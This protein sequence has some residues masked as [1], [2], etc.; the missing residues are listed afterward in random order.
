MS[1][2]DALLIDFL[3]DSGLISR[4]ELDMCTQ[5]A[6]EIGRDVGSVLVQKGKLSP[7]ELR[8]IEGRLLG[9]PFVKLSEKRIPFDTLA[10]I[11]EPIS[12]AHN[13]V[14]IDADDETVSVAVLDLDTLYHVE[15]LF[16]GK[17]KII[18]RFTDEDSITHAIKQYHTYLKH[19]F[20]DT[21]Q[22][23]SAL[24]KHLADAQFD[25]H[26]AADHISVSYIVDALL[27]H[28]LLAEATH[29]HIEPVGEELVITYR[30]A[31][32]L[33]EALVLPQHT[34]EPIVAR[35]KALAELDLTETRLSQ[36]GAFRARIDE[37][38]VA[39]RVT[40]QPALCG[41][42]VLVGI[43]RGGTSGFTLEDLVFMENAVNMCI[44]P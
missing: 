25:R 41:E 23:E 31:G 1:S 40:V 43:V 38:Q 39:F 8:T 11:P 37:R 2:R 15:P 18:T 35:L 28:A 24:I 13:V 34:H 29:I 26:K 33:Y 3:K 42:K 10:L 30:I 17:K 20:G 19:N 32:T 21:I 27:K 16:R 7:R 44:V 14:A 12:R 6:D 9:I 4:R 5:E 36:Y 22:K